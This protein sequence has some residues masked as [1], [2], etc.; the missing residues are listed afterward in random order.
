M[1]RQVIEVIVKPCEHG[2]LRSKAAKVRGG[3]CKEVW[4]TYHD[5]RKG[6]TCEAKAEG[7]QLCDT[8]RSAEERSTPRVHLNR[9]LGESSGH[10]GGRVELREGG[11]SG[12]RAHTPEEACA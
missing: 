4:A 9:P 6:V 10:D 7:R 5:R 3:W 8:L 1:C 12:R 11:D 2:A